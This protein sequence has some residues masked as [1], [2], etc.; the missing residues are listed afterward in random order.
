MTA[1]I[2]IISPSGVNCYLLKTDDGFILVD[3]SIGTARAKLEEDL[4]NAGCGPGDLKLIILTHGDTDHCGNAAYLREKFG[5]PIAMHSDDSGMVATGDMSWNRKPKPDRMTLF[6]KLL[7]SLAGRMVGHAKFDTFK[8]DQFLEDGS[9]LSQYG[10]QAIILYTPGHS[11]GSISVLTA[12]GDLIGGDLFMNMLKPNLHFMID[13][14]NAA[15]AS[16]AKMREL[17]ART[18]YPGHGKPF[19]LEQL[20]QAKY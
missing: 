17:G 2:R 18:I 4:T 7:S 5:V 3:T 15:K 20:A 1:E 8:P 12:N 14:M 6:G 9:K 13:D 16:I 19:L 10:S 11:R